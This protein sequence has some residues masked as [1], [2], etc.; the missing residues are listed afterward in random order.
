MTKNNKNT[1]GTLL[2]RLRISHHLDYLKSG[3]FRTQGP[4]HDKEVLLDIM[5]EPVIIHPSH[6]E[7]DKKSD[8]PPVNF[9]KKIMGKI[10]HCLRFYL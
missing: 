6:L 7:H 2:S 1:L 10:T 5:G 3:D 9:I 8:E 4:Y